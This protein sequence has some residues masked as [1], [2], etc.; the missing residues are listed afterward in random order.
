MIRLKKILV[1][2]ICLSI[3]IN[4]ILVKADEL[5]IVEEQKVVEERKRERLEVE[6]EFDNAF[7]NKEIDEVEESGKITLDGDFS[8][9][10]NMPYFEDED[11]YGNHS[12]NILGYQYYIDKKDKENGKP[13]LYL[14]LDMDTM[15]VTHIRAWLVTNE[16]TF[17]KFYENYNNRD[18]STG[19]ISTLENDKEGVKAYNINIEK[20]TSAE[21]YRVQVLNHN[22]N[23]FKEQG[24]WV[25]EDSGS[26][27][28]AELRIPLEHVMGEDGGTNFN[29]VLGTDL[30]KY[31]T[32]DFIMTSITSGSTGPVFALGLGLVTVLGITIR[33]NKNSEEDI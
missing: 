30:Y 14:R 25:K 21:P 23:L 3:F 16:S 15:P 18:K 29:L 9:W 19:C 26:K 20:L 28:T 5:N 31:P 11:K 10:T 17:N 27:Y 1:M 12:E 32:G 33:K 7:Q 6:K 4:P 22:A 24:Y 2:S 13:Y 8:D